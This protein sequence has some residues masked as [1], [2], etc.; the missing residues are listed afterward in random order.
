MRKQNGPPVA[1][2]FMQV[3]SSFSRLRG[4]IGSFFSYMKRHGSSPFNQICWVSKNIAIA[5]QTVSQHIWLT[6][7]WVNFCLLETS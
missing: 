6:L 3:D 2:P 1:N 7:V 5:N 4:K